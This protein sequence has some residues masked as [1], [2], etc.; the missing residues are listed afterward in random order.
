MPSMVLPSHLH[1]LLAAESASSRAGLAKTR[2]RRA[3]LTLTAARVRNRG[4]RR[5]ALSARAC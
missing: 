5:V 4:R 1:S 3:S 2:R